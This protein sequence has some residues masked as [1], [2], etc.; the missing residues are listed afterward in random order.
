MNNNIQKLLQDSFEHIPKLSKHSV[1]EFDI[2][3]LPGYTNLNFHL[4]SKSN[5]SDWVLR[6]PKQ[7]TNNYINRQSEKHNADVA[8]NLGLAPECLWR[9]SSGYSLSNTIKHSR[10]LE[11]DDF[12]HLDIQKRVMAAVQKL[13]QSDTVFEGTVD[14][15]Q[16][17]TRYYCLMPKPKQNEL[18]DSFQNTRATIKNILQQDKR[19][20][21][22]HNDLVLENILFDKQRIWIIDWEYAA[23]ASPYW[24][25]ATL[26]NAAQLT[27]P[28]AEKFLNLYQ[29]G[30]KSLNSNELNK[31]RDVLHA[32]TNYWMIAFTDIEYKN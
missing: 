20:V 12:K 8:Y 6:V 30:E 1:D 27:S 3:Q 19:L 10:S 31:Y 29:T 18:R 4:L 23:M 32:L 21:P 2:K 22:S 24:D 25:I 9:D 26:C 13:H 28:Q 7:E 14:V 16:L 17:V 5:K 15:E 11:Q